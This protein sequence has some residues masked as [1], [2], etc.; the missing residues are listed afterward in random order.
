MPKRNRIAAIILVAVLALVAA[1]ALITLWPA[2][3]VDNGTVTPPPANGGEAEFDHWAEEGTCSICHAPT[4]AHA[5]MEFN[6]CEDCHAYPTWDAQHPEDTDCA[7]C[8]KYDPPAVHPAITASCVTCHP[9][10]GEAWDFVHTGMET[11]C[12]ECHT[13]PADHYGDDCARCHEPSVPWAETQ[14]PHSASMN[15]LECHDRPHVDYP[16]VSCAQCH[17]GL[18][19]T[20]LFTHP[21]FSSCLTCHAAERPAGHSQGDCVTCHKPPA[22]KPAAHPDASSDCSVC[23]KPPH[24]A[25]YPVGCT[26]CHP[27]VGVAWK[28][29][30]HVRPMNCTLCHASPADSAYTNHPDASCESC[31]DIP[32]KRW[33]DAS[34][35]TMA[36][37]C[38]T[39]HA[40]PAGHP[41]LAC[42]TCHSVPPATWQDGLHPGSGSDCEDCHTAPADTTY[43]AH[44]DT[45]CGSCH[46]IPPAGWPDA[47]HPARDA[48]DGRLAIRSGRST[49]ATMPMLPSRH[50]VSDHTKFIRALLEAKPEL[51]KQQ[52]DG[53]KIWWDR[54]PDDVSERRQM[55]AG[56]VPQQPYVYYQTD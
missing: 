42:T 34:H 18:G 29:A 45:D 36:A 16:G 43:T 22:W 46:P 15:C 41:S 25:D 56:R 7:M 28:P 31:H 21:Q 35:P 30:L 6:R 40:K 52:H 24:R 17:S 38:L 3:E 51:P 53:R 14:F 5:E 33:A 4:P 39:C 32:P 49:I 26:S 47:T 2:E 50:Y 12:L 48:R 11:D 27:L 10:V 55:D 13:V 8:H 19:V 9:N 54:T 23:H 44:P 20:W 37:D 1:I